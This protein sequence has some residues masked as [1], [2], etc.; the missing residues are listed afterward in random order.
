MVKEQ[1]KREGRTVQTV[2]E[3]S[4]LCADIVQHLGNFFVPYVGPIVE[5]NWKRRTESVEHPVE[6]SAGCKGINDP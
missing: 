5:G 4:A 1:G 3:E 6:G 2:N